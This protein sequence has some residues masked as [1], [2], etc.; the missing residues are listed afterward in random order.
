MLAC[1]NS[2]MSRLDP[3]QLHVKYKSFGCFYMKSYQRVFVVDSEQIKL[4]DKMFWL[5]TLSMC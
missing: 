2:G 5:M 4:I 3:S 1:K